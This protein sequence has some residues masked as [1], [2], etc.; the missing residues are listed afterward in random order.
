VPV[1][2]ADVLNVM[3]AVFACQES[4]REKRRIVIREKGER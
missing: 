4:S 2:G 3:E 1:S